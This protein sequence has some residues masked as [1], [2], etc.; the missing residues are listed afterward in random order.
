MIIEIREVSD[1]GVSPKERIYVKEQDSIRSLAI[2]ESY[3]A[4][5]I[6]NVTFFAWGEAW[7]YIR[8]KSATKGI[9][10]E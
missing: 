7:I 10:T 4:H 2:L 6:T 8:R 5:E 1:E 3:P 9:V